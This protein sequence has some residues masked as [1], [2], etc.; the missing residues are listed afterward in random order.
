MGLIDSIPNSAIEEFAKK[1]HPGFP[2]ISGRIHR[3]KD[4]Q[5]GRFGWKAQQASLYDFTIAA[6]A[7]EVGLN[8]PGHEQSRPPYDPTTKPAG[9]DLNQDEVDALVGFIREIPAPIQ[10]T[11]S[12][13]SV[14]AHINKGSE[15]FNSIGCSSCH[16]EKL[17]PVEGLYSD[18]LIHDMG[19]EMRA[20]GSYGN[21]I[22]INESFVNTQ[23][24]PKPAVKKSDDKKPPLPQEWKTPPLWGVRDSAPYLHDGRATTI[25]QAIAF[26]GGEAAS[27]R[28]KYFTLSKSQRE[29]LMAFLRSLVAPSQVASK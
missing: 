1:K 25:E 22:P 2:Q 23:A 16:V 3:L 9:L 11:S 21:T 17:G 10:R 24:G 5:I 27:S 29:N 4:N 19:E 14:A 26:H 13:D 6:C 18:L 15:L 20:V 7:V 28:L 12:N 8:V